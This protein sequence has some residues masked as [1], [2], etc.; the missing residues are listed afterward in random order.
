[1][2]SIEILELVLAELSDKEFEL[3][4]VSEQCVNLYKHG[5]NVCEIIAEPKEV[6]LRLSDD[7]DPYH[8]VMLLSEKFIVKHY[9]FSDEDISK[10]YINLIP[11]KTNKDEESVEDEE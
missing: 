11:K 6:Q 7:E 4:R 3:K 10:N 2:N 9:G 1:M 8:V 5:E